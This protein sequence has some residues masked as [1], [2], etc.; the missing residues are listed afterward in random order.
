MS[1]IWVYMFTYWSM[2]TDHGNDRS[3]DVRIMILQL[4]HLS[5]SI[6]HVHDCWSMCITLDNGT[7]AVKSTSCSTVVFVVV[8][9]RRCLLLIVQSISMWGRWSFTLAT[10]KKNTI[11]LS[12]SLSI[13]L[14]FKCCRIW[15]STFID[16]GFI[17]MFS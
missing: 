7:S 8:V 9:D 12:L 6:D 16:F 11:S 17:F 2:V 13:A 15:S 3:I 1:V 10:K 14:Y 5:L 4:S